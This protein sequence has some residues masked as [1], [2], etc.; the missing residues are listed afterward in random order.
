MSPRPTPR[1][2]AR[3]LSQS[4]YPDHNADGPLPAIPRWTRD[5]WIAALDTMM[6]AHIEMMR[7]DRR[8]HASA[9]F[10]RIATSCRAALKTPQL[11]AWMSNGARSGLAG[12]AGGLAT[13]NRRAQTSRSTIFCRASFDS[14]AQKRHIEGHAGFSGKNLRSNL[15][16]ARRRQ[17]RPSAH[18]NPDELGAYCAF[19]CSIHAATLPAELVIDGGSYPGAF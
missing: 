16:R 15:A 14:D 4:R 6:L 8:R 3:R 10:G 18:G 19:L 7:R 5:D 1:R 2:R 11:E 13:A 9:G 17:P 12:F